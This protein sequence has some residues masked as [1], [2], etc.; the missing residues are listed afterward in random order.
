MQI[1]TINAQEIPG[2]V[3]L[4]V[5]SVK[6]PTPFYL[7]LSNIFKPAEMRVFQKRIHGGEDDVTKIFFPDGA[8]APT[9]ANIAE[10]HRLINV[11]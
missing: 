3:K 7:S 4:P 2:C 10:F 9:I 11:K 5:V 1:V 8:P 6:G